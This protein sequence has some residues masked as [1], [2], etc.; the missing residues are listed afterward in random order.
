MRPM[1][2]LIAVLTFA[3]P[4]SARELRLFSIGSGDLD[5][6]YFAAARAICEVIN[7]TDGKG[8]PES[9]IPDRSTTSSPLT[10][11]NLTW[12]SSSLTGKSMPSR[13]PRYSHLGDR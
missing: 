3:Q 8:S 6:G 4:L 1:F 9:T 12:P 5:G 7:R 13:E 10:R 11:G 2:V